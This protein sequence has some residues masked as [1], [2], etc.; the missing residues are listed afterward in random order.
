MFSGVFIVAFFI[1][2]H[3]I[4]II[5]PSSTDFFSTIITFIFEFFIFFLSLLPISLIFTSIFVFLFFIS[6]IPI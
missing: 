1:V 3:V 2:T 4:S 6:S 5:F